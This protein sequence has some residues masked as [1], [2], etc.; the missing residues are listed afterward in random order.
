[1]ATTRKEGKRRV[2]FK[3]SGE[4][5][6]EVFLAGSFN[7]WDPAQNK[8]RYKDGAWSAT[9]LLPPGRYEYKFVIN[10]VWCVDPHCCEWTANVLGSLNSVVN[11]V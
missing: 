10:G 6:N 8:L 2:V 9:L 3:V 7:D 1:M 11:V 5:Q 4:P